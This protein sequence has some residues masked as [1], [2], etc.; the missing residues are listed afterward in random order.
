V[1]KRD[2]PVAVHNIRRIQA[3][4][5]EA[6]WDD[7]ETLARMFE[8][9]A[10]ISPDSVLGRL[11]AILEATEHRWIQGWRTF[12]DFPGLYE[13]NGF[14]DRGFRDAFKDP[15]AC[16]REQAGHF[17]TAV[18]LVLHPQKLEGRIFFR[19]LRDWAGAPKEMS[20]AEVALRLVI[21]HE[22]APDPGVP[23][24]LV[25][26]KVRRQFRS[27]TDGDLAA[28]HRALE[29]LGRD[30]VFSFAKVDPYM[31]QIEVG[32]ARGNSC[33]DLYLSLAAYHFVQLLKGGQFLD[34]GAMARWVRDNLKADHGQQVTS[35]L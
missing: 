6:S 34:R 11:D 16:S 31:S 17:L 18:G 20:T 15:W 28:F 35:V 9:D 24:P 32:S 30:W 14:S 29:A 23:D 2:D 13:C 22:K 4:N 21:G 19:R 1:I 33:Q 8:D 7:A 10:I 27:C 3:L 26:P 5:Q 12:M 25:L